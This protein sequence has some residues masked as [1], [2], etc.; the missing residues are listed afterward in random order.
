MTYTK[1]IHEYTFTEAV[2]YYNGTEI[3]R[4]HNNDE[5]W[6]DTLSEEEITEDE[7]EEY[8]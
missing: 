6:H 5:T 7:A 3:A 8:L 2:I 4:E 1:K